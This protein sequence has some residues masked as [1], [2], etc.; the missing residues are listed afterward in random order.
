M[1]DFW[2]LVLIWWVCL[3][4]G[5]GDACDLLLVCVGFSEFRGLV[6]FLRVCVM[7]ILVGVGFGGWH[8]FVGFGLFSGL[9][10]VIVIL[11]VLCDLW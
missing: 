5:F 10:V 3:T 1:S 2:R 9:L 11:W 4:C 8:K 6:G 7:Q